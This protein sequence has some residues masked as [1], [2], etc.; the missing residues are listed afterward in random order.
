MSRKQLVI[1][2]V[3]ALAVV[4]VFC[5]LGGLTANYLVETF[6][7]PTWLSIEPFEA[8]TPLPSATP[9]E[10]AWRTPSVARIPTP[11]PPT[12][13]PEPPT[14][15]NTRVIPLTT[16]SRRAT[17][18]AVE[19]FVPDNWEPDDTLA[20]AKPMGVGEWQTHN[21]HVRGDHDWV[22]FEAQEGT[23]YI[24]E[25]SNLGDG[26]DT[27]VHFYDG[28]GNELSSDDDGGEEFLSSRLWWAAAEGGRLYVMVSSFSDMDEGPGANYDLSLRLGEDFALDEY[29]PDD[30]RAQA[31]RIGVGD[32]QTHNRHRGG[33]VDW[34][35]FEAQAGTRYVVE[36]SN[37]GDDADTVI[38]LYDE[39][40]E[41]LGSDDDGGAET[42]ASR[43]EWVAP[44]DGV[45]YVRVEDWLGS[46]AGPGTRY[47]VLVLPG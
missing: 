18:A 26:M 19:T 43:L 16:P 14:P 41:E 23:T 36:T 20:D 27:V 39:A 32:T 29:E 47:D 22:Y 31:R 11:P 1:A 3:L 35:Y 9:A 8:A 10:D 5:C 38:Y 15:T 13:K 44:R 28:E 21:L 37:L 30:S 40:G 7:T 4:C 46:S 2:V 34:V 24:V 45:F 33:D 12:A 42:W 17:P 6:P 25:T